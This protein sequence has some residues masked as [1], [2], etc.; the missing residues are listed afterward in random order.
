VARFV[1]LV[2]EVTEVDAESH[3]MSFDAG[4]TGAGRGLDPESGQQGTPG[5]SVRG[6]LD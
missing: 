3:G 2:I 4:S 5:S 6:N 1:N